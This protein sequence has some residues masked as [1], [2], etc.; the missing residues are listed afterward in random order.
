[1]RDVEQ[2][3]KAMSWDLENDPTP[4]DRE[5]VSAL[6]V[7]KFEEMNT[8]RYWHYE[9]L[10]IEEDEDG[11]FALYHDGAETLKPSRGR[12]RTLLRLMDYP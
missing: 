4:V 6:T 12:V 7:W 11:N 3:A 10:T 9:N 8:F 5:W 2:L 1:M